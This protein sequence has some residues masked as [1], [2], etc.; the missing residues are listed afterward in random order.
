MFTGSCG[1]NLPSFTIRSHVLMRE[2]GNW[3]GSTPYDLQP[4]TPS[5]TP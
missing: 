3:D 1:W 4:P 5:A 2:A